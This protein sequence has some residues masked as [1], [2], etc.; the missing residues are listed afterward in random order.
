M[1]YNHYIS[2]RFDIH[3]KGDLTIEEAMETVSRMEEELYPYSMGKKKLAVIKDKKQGDNVLQFRPREKRIVYCYRDKGASI[4]KQ[5]DDIREIKS[6]LPQ[7]DVYLAMY[8]PV[9]TTLFELNEMVQSYA[10]I[11]EGLRLE[12]FLE[13]SIKEISMQ[14]VIAV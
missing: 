8:G 9:T 7:V 14:V 2:R 6:R 10:S 5:L 13:E 1:R 11:S 12:Y 4:E 3:C